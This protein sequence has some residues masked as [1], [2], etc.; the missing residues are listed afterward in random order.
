MSRV[1]E[2]VVAGDGLRE[3]EGD[4]SRSTRR[5][6]MI[7]KHLGKRQG[8]VEEN[9]VSTKSQRG[10]GLGRVWRGEPAGGTWG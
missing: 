5:V 4:G 1:V 9:R 2:G 7:Q 3:E 8:K 10:R 6:G